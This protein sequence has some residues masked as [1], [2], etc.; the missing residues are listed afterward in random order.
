M[1][2]KR[3]II[4]IFFLMFLS[5]CTIKDGIEILLWAFSE[6]KEPEETEEEK[7]KNLLKFEEA[8]RQLDLY[9]AVYNEGVNNLRLF[10]E[11]GYDPNVCKG[12]L[13]YRE[14]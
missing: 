4:I 8:Q 14:G 6:K 7:Q 11:E 1:K 2:K 12:E 5:S 13:G 10:L 3:Y 9:L